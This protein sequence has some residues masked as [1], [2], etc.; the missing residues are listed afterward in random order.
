MLEGDSLFHFVPFGMT[1][2]SIE[3]G[4]VVKDPHLPLRYREIS[5]LPILHRSPSFLTTHNTIRRP[6]DSYKGIAR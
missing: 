6:Q 2:F 5:T 3:G 4:L 1:P